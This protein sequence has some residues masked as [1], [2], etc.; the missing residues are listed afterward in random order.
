MYSSRTDR[1][2]LLS[3]GEST[4]PTQK[5][6]SASRP[7]WVTGVWSAAGERRGAGGAA[8]VRS[9]RV[10][11]AGGAGRGPGGRAGRRRAGGVGPAGREVADGAGHLDAGDDRIVDR[12]VGGSEA[13]PV[14]GLAGRAAVICLLLDVICSSFVSCLGIA[15]RVPPSTR[16]MSTLPRPCWMPGFRRRRRPGCW[17][18]A[19]LLGAAGPPL[20]GQ[21]GGVGPG[22]GPG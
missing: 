5:A 19:G 20:P 16:R 4:P 1:A 2:T 12:A 9:G 6:I 10:L 14:S 3:S 18:A 22:R 13:V 11:A 21:G 17:P 8:G 15:V 7:R